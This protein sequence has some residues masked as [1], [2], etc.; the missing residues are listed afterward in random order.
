MTSYSALDI[1]II[2]VISL[3]AAILIALLICAI[4]SLFIED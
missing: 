4:I 3:S 1:A 2:S